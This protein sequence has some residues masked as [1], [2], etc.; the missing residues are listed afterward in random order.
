M[1]NMADYL[2]WLAIMV[3]LS[4]IA[5]AAIGVVKMP[6]K[7]VFTDL[8]DRPV[9][10]SVILGENLM[11]A[12]LGTR[13]RVYRNAD[14]LTSAI[15]SHYG[16]DVSNRQYRD[17]ESGKGRIPFDVLLAFVALTHP[18]DGLLGL[19]L[20]A[21]EEDYRESWAGLVKGL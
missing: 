19:T 3:G 2:H 9:L 5:P 10:D 13:G 6:K 11:S 21:V 7:S 12:R 16:C 8:R 1:S 4:A 20:P 17:Y 15:R 18:K 14:V